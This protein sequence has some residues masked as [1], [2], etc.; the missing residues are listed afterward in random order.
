[1]KRWVVG[2][3]GASGIR[4][5]LRLIRLIVEA[6][7]EV[8]IVFSDAA[9]RVLNDEEGTAA[10]H[11]SLAAEIFPTA[12]PGNVV[13]HNP[14]DI[15]ASIASGSLICEGMV[16]APC[17]MAT[18]GAIAHGVSQNLVHRAAEVAL[19]EGRRLVLAPRE[20]PLSTIYLENMAALS[21]AGARIVPAMPGFYHQPKTIDDLVDMMVMKIL[22][23]MG[24][25]IDLVKRWQGR[26]KE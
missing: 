3:T 10:T 20:T 26:E 2:V 25:H 6:V 5:G 19:K 13:F 16:I 1:M 9:L 4:Y 11:S 17:S 7:D 8:H 18:L 21:R 24:I 23:Q 12:R 14:R 22:D 15:G